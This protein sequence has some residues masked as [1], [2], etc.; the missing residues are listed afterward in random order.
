MFDYEK[1]LRVDKFPHIW[2]A[3]CGDGIMLKSLLRAVDDLGWSKDE[4]AMVSGIGCSSRVTGYVDFQT[5]HSLHGRAI[6]FATGVKMHRPDLKVV[7]LTGDGDAAAI[8]G[9]HLIHAARRNIDITVIMVNNS[10]YGMTGGQV[11]P[12]TPEG[13]RATTAPYGQ[14][15]PGFDIPKLVIAAGATYVARGTAFH[16]RKL[17]RMIKDALTNPGFSLVEVVVACPTVFGKLNKKGTPAQMLLD[18][19]ENS[20]D[21]ARAA[22]MSPEE[23]VGKIITGVLHQ[24]ER[25]EYAARYQELVLSLGGTVRHPATS[26]TAR[27]EA[28]AVV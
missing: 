13:A 16:A 8:G 1:Y 24:V 23:L 6:P 14:I 18:Q 4:I 2:C 27:E 11:S 28:A 20:I 17:E 15:D 26:V 9:N 19:K 25:P 22:K 21:V 7:V 5:I 10:I 3:G 12:A